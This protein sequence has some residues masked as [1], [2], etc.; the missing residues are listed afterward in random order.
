MCAY[1]DGFAQLIHFMPGWD[2]AALHRMLLEQGAQTL[3]DSLFEKQEQD[4]DML[5]VPRFKLRDDATA[6]AARI[7]WEEKT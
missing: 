3:M 1:S 5:L 6:A 4:R 7:G 2:A